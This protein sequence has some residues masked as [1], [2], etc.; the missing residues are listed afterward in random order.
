MRHNRKSFRACYPNRGKVMGKRSVKRWIDLARWRRGNEVKMLQN[1][2]AREG[3]GNLFFSYFVLGENPPDLSAEICFC[4]S[5]DKHLLYTAM[6]E[7]PLS[8][9]MAEAD[10]KACEQRDSLLQGKHDELDW[11]SGGF[12]PCKW[13]NVNG[14]VRPVLYT[15]RTL[16]RS[17]QRWAE[18]GSC[19]CQEYVLREQIRILQSNDFTCRESVSVDHDHGSY[20]LVRAVLSVSE[21]TDS[22]LNDFVRKFIESG[23]Q[24]WSGSVDL[25]PGPEIMAKE[26]RRMEDYLSRICGKQ[27][28]AL[29]H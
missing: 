1:R 25:K 3:R 8:L 19:T 13:C 17:P 2:I 18:L 27:N 5:K 22:C 10:R 29:V 21:I 24:G 15:S 23:E 6:I 20:V 12:V 26:I 14:K 11:L 7:T 4:S 28:Q 9:A 16:Q